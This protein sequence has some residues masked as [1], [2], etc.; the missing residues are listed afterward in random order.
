MK[1][2]S[3]NIGQQKIVDWN[4]RKNDEI[5]LIESK[6]KSFTVSEIFNMFYEKDYNRIDLFLISLY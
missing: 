3:T 1:V 5:I 4:G 6:N 2:I